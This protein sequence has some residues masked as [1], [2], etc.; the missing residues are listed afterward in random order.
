MAHVDDAKPTRWLLTAETTVTPCR[1]FQWLAQSDPGQ[2]S[3]NQTLG[4]PW[5]NHAGWNA[6][7]N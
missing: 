1:R 5:M 3:V 4:F 7:F 6:F 2:I